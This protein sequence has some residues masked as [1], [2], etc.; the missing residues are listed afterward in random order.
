MIEHV[1]GTAL[2]AVSFL[3]AALFDGRK[4]YVVCTHCG[5]NFGGSNTREGHMRII[6]GLIFQGIAAARR[7]PKEPVPMYDPNA[8]TA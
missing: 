2:K 7:I 8:S 5:K 4:L 1:V 6:D 3:P